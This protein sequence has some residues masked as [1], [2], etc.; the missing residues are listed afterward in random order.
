MAS[1][2]QFL[3]YSTIK[4][5]MLSC[6]SEKLVDL[7]APGIIDL[8]SE[9]GGGAGVVPLEME[10]RFDHDIVTKLVFPSSEL[11]DPP[12]AVGVVLNSIPSR[13]RRFIAFEPDSPGVW[14]G[15]VELRLRDFFH[16]A[17]LDPVMFRGESAIASTQHGKAV[18]KAALLGTGPGF[19]VLFDHFAESGENW[20]R[21]EWADFEDSDVLRGFADLICF[22]DIQASGEL[23]ILYL[24]AGIDDLKQVLSVPSGNS[25][26]A[27]I[28]DSVGTSIMLYANNRL[29]NHVVNQISA[30]SV[31]EPS[32]SSQECL[33]ALAEWERQIVAYWS[34]TLF[35]D[36]G[37]TASVRFVEDALDPV[38]SVDLSTRL[39]AEVQR[40]TE[41]RARFDGL[42][43]IRKSFEG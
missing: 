15:R 43:K 2:A 40:L 22:L 38:S 42:A 12:L 36:A 34:R 37:T 4:T 21:M 24:N 30:V 28:R 27:R 17:T 20:L 11:D 33:D 14:G 9:L 16:S 35:P 25:H 39:A 23:P 3:P 1:T 8:R 26:K 7:E 41:L 19:R 29:T 32:R 6:S 13:V 18:H 31:S 5:L 10:I